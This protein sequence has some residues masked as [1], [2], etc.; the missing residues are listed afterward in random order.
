M[1]QRSYTEEEVIMIAMIAALHGIMVAGIYTWL[2]GWN[3]F[4]LSETIGLAVLGIPYL[5]IYLFVGAFG[6]TE[7]TSGAITEEHSP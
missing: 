1:S 3:L 4:G 6:E 2:G 5:F 7:A